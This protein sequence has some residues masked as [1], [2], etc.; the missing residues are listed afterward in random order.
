MADAE[1]RI[2]VMAEEAVAC[3]ESE[4]C[5]LFPSGFKAVGVGLVPWVLKPLLAVLLGLMLRQ[6]YLGV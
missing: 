2:Q 6:F 3:P 4:H 5:H 1:F